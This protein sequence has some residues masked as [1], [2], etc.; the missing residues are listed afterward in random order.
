[1]PRIVHFEIPVDDPERAIAFYRQVF[2][3][4]IATWDGPMDYW[5]C[6]TGP[7]GELGIDGALTRREGRTPQPGSAINIVVAV[8]SV[9]DVTAR[10]EKAG[11]VLVTEKLPV[12]GVGW[13]VGFLD[14][15]GNRLAALEPD[16]SAAFEP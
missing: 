10:I 1:M 14:T 3:W 7:E 8:G 4:S 5:L 16:L 11:G 15:E 2:D 13:I 12:P 9:D 6:S